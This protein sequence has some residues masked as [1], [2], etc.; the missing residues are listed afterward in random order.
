[1]P[2]QINIMEKLSIV[3]PVYG[4]EET[5][6]EIIRKVDS[7]KYQIPHEIL[8]VNDGSKDKT[9][10]KIKEL[11]DVSSLR[12][13]SYEENH[14]KGYATREGIKASTGNILIIQDA[15]LE[16][17]PAD[18]PSIIQPI[19]DGKVDVV[20]GSR[21]KGQIKKISALHYIGNRVLTW[22]T[23][24]L[25][26]SSLT[27]ME[28]CYKAFSRKALE[29]ILI[30]E[31][32]FEIEPEITVELL[33]KGYKIFEAPVTYT[34]RGF[35]EGKKITWKSGVKSGLILLK[36]SFPFIYQLTQ[37][38]PAEVI[39]RYLRQREVVAELKKTK[40]VVL[41]V[42]CGFNYLFLQ[43]IHDKIAAGYGFDLKVKEKNLMKLEIR[44]HKFEKKLPYPD[45]FFD[46]VTSI[47]TLEHFDNPE[48]IIPEFARVLKKGGRVILTTPTKKSKDLLDTLSFLRILNPQ[49]IKDHKGYYNPED[50]IN[51][52]NVEGF[53]EIKTKPFELGF[54]ILYV[55]EK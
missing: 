29:D 3:I 37:D 54:N 13:V 40:P 21:F 7:V 6:Q 31:D 44:F 11:K 1:M 30:S 8:V 10:E 24:I 36:H 42:G 28:T 49:E 39:V 51:M 27:D 34:A 26:S 5:V 50:V 14:G 47:A 46:Y 33:K 17:N 12:L 35:K 52:F 53:N 43:S 22:M 48:D 55:F 2:E 25:F 41:D 16:Y 23:N 32:G 38:Y 45:N 19:L 15:D 18:I 20:Y 9:L 4:E